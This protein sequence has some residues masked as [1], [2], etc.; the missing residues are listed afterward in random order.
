MSEVMTCYERAALIAAV[1]GCRVAIVHNGNTG[2]GRV[3]ETIAE[4][5]DGGFP[6]AKEHQIFDIV[7]PRC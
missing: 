7:G 2:P 6:T 3:W 5:S 4:F 1:F